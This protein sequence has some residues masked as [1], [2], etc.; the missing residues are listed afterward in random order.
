MN[1]SAALSTVVGVGYFRPAP[2]T[3]GSAAGLA[4]AYGAIWLAGAAGLLILT[5]IVTGAGFWAVGKYLKTAN[6]DDPSEVVIDEVA[7]QCLTLLVVA[8][9]VDVFTLDLFVAGFALFRVFDILK[10]WPANLAERGLPGAS[11]VMVDDLVAACYA[12]L[13][14]ILISRAI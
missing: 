14:L 2:G 13:I 9:F 10:V 3:W 4:L 7:G 12:G 8:P 5:I 6:T 1:L 11:G